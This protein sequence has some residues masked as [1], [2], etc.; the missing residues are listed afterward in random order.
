MTI[1]Y[2]QV[3]P[4]GRLSFSVSTHLILSGFPLTS[5]YLAEASQSAFSWLYTIM[6]AV[7]QKYHEMSFIYNYSH[8][9]YLF[10]NQPVLNKVWNNNHTVHMNERNRNKIKPSHVTFKLNTRSIV[11]FRAIIKGWLHCLTS[12]S[13]IRFLFRLSMMSDHGA[14]PIFFNKIGRPEHSLTPHPSTSD[15]ISFLP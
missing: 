13:K 2:Y 10:C 12:E 7:V 11:R 8:F 1:I 3:I 6:C 4:S 5:F 9:W 15:N 14:N